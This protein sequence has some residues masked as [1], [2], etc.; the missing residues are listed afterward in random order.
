[1]K[2][3]ISVV[4]GIKRLILN[5]IFLSEH[6]WD[7][8][9]LERGLGSVK[10]LSGP[11]RICLTNRSISLFEIEIYSKNTEINVSEVI[12][13]IGEILLFYFPNNVL[14]I[15]NLIINFIF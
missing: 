1:M 8:E 10:N 15:F 13:F 14:I 7:V 3:S 9:V 5:I 11:R 2:L 12:N 6:V 4:K